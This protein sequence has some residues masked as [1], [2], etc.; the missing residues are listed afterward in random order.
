MTRP[1]AI[2]GQRGIRGQLGAVVDL[3]NDPR[4][5]LD[6]GLSDAYVCAY[7]VRLVQFNANRLPAVGLSFPRLIEIRGMADAVRTTEPFEV[8]PYNLACSSTVSFIVEANF[9]DAIP[10]LDGKALELERLFLAFKRSGRNDCPPKTIR[11]FHER[12]IDG[13]AQMHQPQDPLRPESIRPN[14]RPASPRIRK[15]A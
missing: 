4:L 10:N 7:L 5:A 12:I 1:A 9:N 2:S 15:L 6:R 11:R 3:G 14:P 8:L 13:I